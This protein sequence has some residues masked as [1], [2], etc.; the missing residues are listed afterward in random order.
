MT[1][2]QWKKAM[3]IFWKDS[4]ERADL[5]VNVVWHFFVL[6]RWYGKILCDRIVCQSDRRTQV[7]ELKNH[8]KREDKEQKKN[9]STWT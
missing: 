3:N 9:S 2:R 7:R 5:Y 1:P 8:E 4:S 6:Q